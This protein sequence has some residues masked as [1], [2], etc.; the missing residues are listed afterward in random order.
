MTTNISDDSKTY[1]SRSALAEKLGVT[2]KEL[3]Q[4]L[5]E[6]GWLAHQ[7][8]AG[9]EGKKKS[10]WLLTEKG[11][12]EGG[13]YRESKKFGRYIVWPDK[14][15][16][17]PAI[18]TITETT[19]TATAIGTHFSIPA[20][21]VNKL[22]AEMG[23]ITSF[24]KGW[25]VSACGE[26]NGG[27]QNTNKDTGVPYVTW[28]RSILDSLA[29]SSQVKHYLGEKDNTPTVLING[30]TFYRALDG[31]Y[32]S[33]IQELHIAHFLY[34]SNISYAY[35]RKLSLSQQESIVVDFYLPKESL[36]I[37]YHQNNVNPG[38]LTQ[39]LEQDEL[40]KKYQLNAIVIT[41]ADL[42]SL[43]QYLSKSLIKLGVSHI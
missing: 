41:D 2:L 9:S 4:L 3:T 30:S 1:L 6:S 19:I 37:F 16:S 11:K 21:I 14:V 5:I 43:D 33:S 7:E 25:R 31:H 10:D 35:Q 18:K 39:Q 40:I 23:W 8:N 27:L 15:L 24:S 13:I 28:S 32:F 26:A 12:F 22:F 38:R 29:L 17:H 42:E 20:K 36:F 34:L